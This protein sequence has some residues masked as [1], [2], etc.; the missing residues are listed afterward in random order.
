MKRFYIKTEENKDKNTKLNKGENKNSIQSI[1]QQENSNILND[2]ISLLE[3]LWNK[4]DVTKNFRSHFIKNIT[5]LNFKERDLI[6]E[7][8]KLNIEKIAHSLNELKNEIFSREKKL[9]CLKDY[10]NRIEKYIDE[11]NIINKNSNVFK[12]VC[13]NITELISNRIKIINLIIFINKVILSNKEKWDLNEIKKKYLY[14][15]NYLDKIKEDMVFLNN[16]ILSKFIDIN[17]SIFVPFLNS[18]TIY[19]K[20]GNNNKIKLIIDGNLQTEINNLRYLLSKESINNNSSINTSTNNMKIK[21][22]IKKNNLTEIELNAQSNYNNNKIIFNRFSHNDFQIYKIKNKKIRKNTLS[23]I[24]LKISQE[25]FNQKK[26]K[27]YN[28]IFKTNSPLFSSIGHSKERKFEL[29]N[30]TQT[31]YDEIKKL[32]LNEQNKNNELNDEIIS[33]KKLNLELRKKNLDLIILNEEAMNRLKEQEKV[34]YEKDNDINIVQIE[35]REEK[36]KNKELLEQNNKIINNYKNNSEILELKDKIKELE[37]ILYE[38]KEE[39]KKYKEE[40][41]KYFD[42]I[43]NK[44]KEIINLKNEVNELKIKE[45]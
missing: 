42:I 29:S 43:D 16:S 11:G 21:K 14:E 41:K 17:D 30:V 32:L 28:E 23:N 9:K 10:N 6:I 5:N 39:N 15:P 8:E 20:D 38:K 18:S 12:E 24:N 34:S 37:K 3:N 19:S 45:E 44:N 25:I 4:A 26:G 36:I 33:L 7:N 13:N 40:L 22:K 1:N 35:L 2:E 31:K 27:N